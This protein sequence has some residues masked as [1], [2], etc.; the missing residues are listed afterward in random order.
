MTQPNM[1]RVC[2]Y[3]GCTNSQCC[4]GGCTWIDDAQAICISCLPRVSVAELLQAVTTEYVVFSEAEVRVGFL[5]LQIST[6][7]GLVQLALRHPSMK[8]TQGIR[9]IGQI[10]VDQAQD[11]LARHRMFSL[12]ELIRRGNEP[13]QDG[14][15]TQP[16]SSQPTP[17]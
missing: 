12:A 10:F 2:K 5:P 15:P 14:L 11:C 4:P 6:I 3:C 1:E 17:P 7:V 16:E 13:A 8:H 9:D